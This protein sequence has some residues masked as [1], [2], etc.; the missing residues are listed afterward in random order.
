MSNHLNWNFFNR[1]LQCLKNVSLRLLILRIFFLPLRSLLGPLHLFILEKKSNRYVYYDAYV[2]LFSNNLSFK[3]KRGINKVEWSY[4]RIFLKILHSFF[5]EFF[6][7]KHSRW[8]YFFSSSCLPHGAAPQ[9]TSKPLAPQ[10]A[11]TV[12]YDC[13]QMFIRTPTF[14]FFFH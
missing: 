1:I 3:Q 10:F 6:F 12:V 8:N 4:G 2:Y 5:L 13:T 11:V 9:F 14:I 7:F